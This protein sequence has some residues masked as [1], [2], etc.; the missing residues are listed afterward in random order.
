MLLVGKRD[1]RCDRRGVGVEHLSGVSFSKERA[2]AAVVNASTLA[3]YPP[4]V[5]TEVSSPIAVGCRN[6]SLFDP[7][8]APASALTIT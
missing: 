6:S 7:P 3:A 5:R 8:I 1:E 4:S 2:G